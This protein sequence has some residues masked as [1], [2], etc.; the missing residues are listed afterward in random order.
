MVVAFGCSAVWLLSTDCS[1]DC[2]VLVPLVESDWL[3]ALESPVPV[4]H[5]AHKKS[6]ESNTEKKRTMYT[7]TVG[8]Q[9]G[10]LLHVE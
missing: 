7:F 6:A 8:L 2:E 3:G 9:A 4:L 1:E 10:P 5:A